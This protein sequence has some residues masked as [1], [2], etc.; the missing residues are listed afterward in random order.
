MRIL[1]SERLDNDE[2]LFALAL[3]P[4]TRVSVALCGGSQ[5]GLADMSLLYEAWRHLH[6]PVALITPPGIDIYLPA[7]IRRGIS[8]DRKLNNQ[9][10]TAG[11][12]LEDA[13]MVVVGPNMHLDSSQ[14]VFFSKLLPAINVPVVLTDE[15]LSLW[16]I[17]S[18]IRTNPAVTW[19]ASSQ[20]AQK[21]LGSSEVIKSERGVFAVEEF[22]RNIPLRSDFVM[23]HDTTNLYSYVF[24]SDT[25]IHTPLYGAGDL[26]RN[27]ALSL[28]PITVFANASGVTIEQ[29]LQVLHAIF[30]EL[31]KKRLWQPEEWTMLA[32]RRLG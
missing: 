14:Q 30:A 16:S 19:L 29:R 22:M 9:D 5:R 10:I 8:H 11:E 24:A 28:M 13:D 4:M 6:L 18:V 23:L 2:A 20:K 7:G 31:A 25:F 3:G 12:I 1:Q 32:K 26:V 15:A 27:M 21:I 17:D